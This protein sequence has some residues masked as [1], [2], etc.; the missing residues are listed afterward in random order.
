[1]KVKQRRQTGQG[2][3]DPKNDTLV[4][5]LSFLFIFCFLDLKLKEASN[6][7]TPMAMEKK[8]EELNTSLLSLGKGPGKRQINL[9]ENIHKIIVL[10]QSNTTEKTTTSPPPTP[11]KVKWGI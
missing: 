9:I 4:S 8:V 6:L 10:L 5:S 2:P 1:M 11:A 3:Q 7:E